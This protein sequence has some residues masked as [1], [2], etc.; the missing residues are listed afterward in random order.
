MSDIIFKNCLNLDNFTFIYGFIYI[1]FEKC[2]ELL[3]NVTTM[4][5]TKKKQFT[6][7]EVNLNGFPLG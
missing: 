3:F 1:V 5:A 6:Q 2:F 7:G 4:R